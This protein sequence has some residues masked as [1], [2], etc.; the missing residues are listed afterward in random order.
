MPEPRA[1]DPVQIA[2]HLDPASGSWPSV[3]S[4]GL[5]GSTNDVARDVDLSP[6]EW[7]VIVADAQHAGRGR[8]GAAWHS[9]PGT[10]IHLSLTTR[11]E[12]PVMKWPAASLVVGAAVAD[13]LDALPGV[14]LRLKWPN[15]LMIRATDN[16]RKAGGILCERHQLPGQ[17]A[18]WI[19]GVGVNVSTPMSAFPQSLRDHAGTLSMTAT[20]PS[21][22]ELV[23][24]IASAV[25]SAIGRWTAAGGQINTPA[26]EQRLLFIGDPVDLDCGDGG[27]DRRVRLLGLHPSGALRVADVNDPGGARESLLQPLQITAAYGRLSWH[28]A[29]RLEPSG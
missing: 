20:P 1:L 29:P 25:R 24:V 7:A 13:A 21:R 8:V 4:L 16:W 23:G 11:L 17:P 9:P 27:P 10:A 5:T 22:E 14:Q 15:D 3:I 26:I 6:G 28:A 19:A 2:A 18:R 12:L